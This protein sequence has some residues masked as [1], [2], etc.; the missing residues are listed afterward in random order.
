V[1]PGDQTDQITLKIVNRWGQLMFEDQNYLNTW[2]G[3]DQSGEALPAD[4]YFYEFT[5]IG[6]TQTGFIQIQR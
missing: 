2:G 5:I 4:T 6:T 3:Q 1:I